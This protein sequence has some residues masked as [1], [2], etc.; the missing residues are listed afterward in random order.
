MW[1]PEPAQKEQAQ[2]ILDV[3]RGFDLLAARP[4]VDT[5]RLAYVGHSLG[6]TVGGALAS[7]ERRPLGFVLMAGLPSLTH[8]YSGA[9]GRAPEAF[10]TL[11]TAEEQARYI[12][13][14]SPLDAVHHIGHAAPARLLFQFAHQDPYIS[15]W[16][17]ALYVEAASSPKEVQ[18]FDTDHG[19]QSEE[20]RARRGE[21]LGKLLGLR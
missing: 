9:P 2:T 1:D 5:A 6:S 12:A 7:V 13:A 19:F 10:R 18:W 14:L 4:D 21:W 11:L 15:D 16:D 20:A 17:A 3:R 8:A